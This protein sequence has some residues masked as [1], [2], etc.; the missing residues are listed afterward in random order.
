MCVCVGVGEKE[1]EREREFIVRKRVSLHSF[2]AGLGDVD[3]DMIEELLQK[4]L[5]QHPNVRKHL[6]ILG[7]WV[8]LSGLGISL[9]SHGH[10]IVCL[11][12]TLSVN[13]L[14]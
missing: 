9:A 13:R 5:D 11:P 6:H 14:C 1:R 8:G 2:V 7:G 3:V 12:S 4:Q 10:C